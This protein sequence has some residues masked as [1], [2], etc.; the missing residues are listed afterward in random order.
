MAYKETV[1]GEESLKNLT[2][3]NIYKT[4]LLFSF[5]LVLAGV[6]SQG[7]TIINTVIA[8][9][10]IGD[11]ALAVIGAISPLDVFVNSLFWG[12]GSG[13]GIYVAQLFGAGKF[14]RMKSV[15]VNNLV[16]SSAL[17]VI[18][19]VI[20]VVFRYE[21]FALFQVDKTLIDE[22]NK[23]FTISLLGKVVVLFATN[24]VFVFNA[25]GNSAYPLIMS[26]ISSVLNIAISVIG[27]TA[28]SLGVETLALGNVLSAVTVSILYM[29]K[30]SS[31]FGKLGVKH[32]KVRL[33]FRTIKETSQ[34]SI[35]TTCQQS[36]MYLST[37]VLSP[38]VNMIGGAASASYA[39]SC[40]IYDF[41]AAFFQSSAKTVGNYTAQCY[42]AGK[43]HLLKKG[44]KVGFLQNL[45]YVLPILLGCIFF[46]DGVASVFYTADADRI[47]VKYTVDFMHWCMPFLI[48]SVV[49]NL[50]HNFFRGVAYLKA[51]LIATVAGSVIRI[52]ASYFLIGPFGI[53]GY[54]FGWVLSWLFDGV[55]G[56]C[57]YC[58]GKWRK[59][60]NIN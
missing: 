58:F 44:L 13:I 46:A 51:L 5:P 32:H 6:L 3:G 28:F 39:V 49:A 2:G 18:I 11:D 48:F 25:M 55:A 34:F 57:F 15:I 26:L 52:V 27:V 36:I 33:G 60:I 24:C 8:G 7:Y 4:F 20:M 35:T 41:N 40:R 9:K 10:L 53:H 14:F 1:K 23:Y 59:K 38:M 43:Y 42:G 29:I 54:Y 30:L 12:Y 16:F 17:I 37:L 19:S 56:I 47:A 22:C 31:M 21:M 45:L 50:F